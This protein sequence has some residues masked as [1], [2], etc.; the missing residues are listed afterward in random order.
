MLEAFAKLEKNRFLRDFSNGDKKNKNGKR[1]S[2][3]FLFFS[4]SI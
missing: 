1:L 3:T 4:V 2:V